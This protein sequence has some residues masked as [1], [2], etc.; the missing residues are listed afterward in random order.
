[1]A[2]RGPAV[3]TIPPGIA[4]LDAIAARV[5]EEAEGDPMALAHTHIL[6]PT[7]RAVRALGEAFLRAGEGRPMVLPRVSPLGDVEEEA[8]ALSAGETLRFAGALDLPPA[9]PELRRRL[10]LA[11]LVLGLARATGGGPDSIEHATL[12]A[13]ELSRLLDQVQTERLDFAALAGLVPEALAEHWRITLDFLRIVTESW[14]AVLAEEGGIDPAERRNRLLEAQAAA[15]AEAPPDGPVI[16]A[17]STG[18]IPATADLLAVV[19]RL[20]EGR[21]V[22]PGL[23]RHTDDESWDLLTA[24]PTHP[25]HGLARLL[26]RFGVRRHEV[27]DWPAPKPA[28]AAEMRAHF[29]AEAMRPA[30]TSEA[31]RD[32]DNLSSDATRGLRRIDCPT[33]R[34][35]AGI[36]ALLLREALEV[37]G[38]TAALVTP[39]RGLARRVAGELKRWDIDIDDSAGEPLATTPVGAFLRL[40][41]EMVAA[42][43]APVP[44]LAALKHP[45]AA[46]GE[47]PSA[48]RARVRALERAVLRGPRPSSDFGGLATAL[49][50]AADDDRHDGIQIW[51]EELGEMVA[52]FAALVT[53]PDAV[54][55]EL[56]ATHVAYAEALAA[57]DCE[58]GPNRLWAGEAGEA[59]AGFIADLAQSARDLPP[60]A[61]REYPG[62]LDALM[63]GIVVRPRWGR[64]PRLH[65]WGPLEARLLHAGLVVIGGL[66]EGAWPPE[67]VA[68]PWMSRPMRAEF[69]LAPPER[70]IGLSAHDFAQAMGAEEVVLTRA[71]R[72][73]GAPSVPSRW[74]LRLDTVLKGADLALAD[75]SGAWAAWR[76]ALDAP[77]AVAPV[78]APAPRPPVAARPRRLSVTR[79]GIWMR[80]PYA[81]YARH[82]LKLTPLD[83][84]DADPG[85]AER[86]TFIHQ[87]LERFLAECPGAPPGDAFERLLA[88]GRAAFGAALARPGVG[89]F[90]WPRFERIARWFVAEQTRA[91]GEGRALASEAIGRLEIA[92]PGGPFVL[93]ARADRIDRRADGALAIIDYKTGTVPGP[94][95]VES[96][97]EPQL[98]LEAAIA[99]A[100]GFEG[101]PVGTVAALEYWRLTGAEPPGER[102]PLRGDPGTLAEDA[103]AGL[104]ALVAVFDD[105]STPYRPQPDPARAPR[106]DDYEHLARVREWSVGAGEDGA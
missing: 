79:I 9:I 36:I 28:A 38:R 34:E 87:A 70:R 104:S 29:V 10:L 66:N 89:A 56:L 48:F 102:K 20:P 55:G 39:D 76:D 42:R 14:P 96:G 16:A 61:G 78:S 99:A 53:K 24:E 5:L 1:M 98:P 50:A 95:L 64:H 13:G 106:F 57:S 105:P 58:S 23:D 49:A 30:A 77:I 15:W 52:A 54:F 103:L 17:G 71:E 21:V 22:L 97:L 88:H 25:Q 3:Y 68:D 60:M 82:V 73:E 47:D 63:A 101:V 67:P 81:I 84:L 59:A 26:E 7:R 90:W 31:W 19:A 33:P 80:D 93:T 37:Q 41:A 11:R 4:F 12:L 74:L 46:G 100:G 83:P 94:G 27:A 92:A 32:I 45:L 43:A 2:R 44:L 6:V 62:L 18:S 65:I 69:G 40:T 85:A 91:A 51:V 8:L 35:E 72:V 86:G 75:D